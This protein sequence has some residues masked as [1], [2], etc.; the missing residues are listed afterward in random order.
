MCYGLA[1]ASCDQW[2]LK[3]GLEQ[4]RQVKSYNLRVDINCYAGSW[5]FKYTVIFY[6]DTQLLTFLVSA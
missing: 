4:D 5:Q 6:D 3:E 2:V 1:A